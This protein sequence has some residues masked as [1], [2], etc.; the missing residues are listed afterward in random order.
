MK[1]HLK[2]RGWTEDVR[3]F[4]LK[5]D[6]IIADLVKS[7]GTKAWAQISTELFEVYGY[8]KKSGKQCR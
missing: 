4:L 3:S 5:E 8:K 1:K 2:N 6:K 7:Y